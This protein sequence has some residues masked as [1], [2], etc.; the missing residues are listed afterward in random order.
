MLNIYKK[1]RG[2]ALITT[3]VVLLVIFVLGLAFATNTW[4][5]YKTVSDIYRQNRAFNT[6]RAGLNYTQAEFLTWNV[7]KDNPYH[8]EKELTGSS[9]ILDVTTE[10]NSNYT[11]ISRGFESRGFTGKSIQI[12]AK[13]EVVT[14]PVDGTK[15]VQINDISEQL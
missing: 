11:L 6:A 12:T 4:I 2:I 13:F 8:E 3:L 7:T 1:Q 9:F 5:N 15:A 14:D 10:D